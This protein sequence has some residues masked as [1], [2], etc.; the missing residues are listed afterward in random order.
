MPDTSENLPDPF[1]AANPSPWVARLVE[2][3]N[4]D[5]DLQRRGALCDVQCLL[6]IGDAVFHLQIARGQIVSADAGPILMRSW[7][8][9]IKASTATWTRFWQP[10]P[11][12][13]W[14]DLFALTKRGHAVIEGDF[15]PL[16]THL[17]YFKD[18]LA[19][20]RSFGART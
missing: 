4:A 13:G 14:H 8:F 12:A 9:A 2:A 7:S 11:E 18:V 6:G 20:P 5:A 10:V 1:N 17:Q 19:V 3:V 16:L 15:K